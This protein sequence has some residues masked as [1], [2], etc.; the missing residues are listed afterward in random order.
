MI[1]KR[2]TYAWKWWVW[3][4]I[5]IF[6]AGAFVW[7]YATKGNLGPISVFVC[8]WLSGASITQ[9]YCDKRREMRGGSQATAVDLPGAMNTT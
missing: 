8:G 3:L 4:L 6:W 1:E 5:G 9:A 2:R 7:E